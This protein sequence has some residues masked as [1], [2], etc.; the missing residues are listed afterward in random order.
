MHME[1]GSVLSVHDVSL[2]CWGISG[3]NRPAQLCVWARIKTEFEIS[4]TAQAYSTLQKLT[5][6]LYSLQTDLILLLLVGCGGFLTRFHP[7]RYRPT[8]RD[9]PRQ[10][11]GM[12]W[13]AHFLY[14]NQGW[15]SFERASKMMEDSGKSK[16]T[17]D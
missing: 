16:K 15:P 2:N 11:T 9:N 4:R 7:E 12:V 8:V 17:L 3:Y 14:D 1:G 13:T 5:F 10:F 6:F